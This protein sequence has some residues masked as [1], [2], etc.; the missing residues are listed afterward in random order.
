MTE[1]TTEV[2]RINISVYEWTIDFL[3]KFRAKGTKPLPLSTFIQFF[4]YCLKKSPAAFSYFLG[5]LSTPDLDAELAKMRK[6]G[7]DHL[8]IKKSKLAEEGED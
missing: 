6:F 1:S 3:D 2:E 7:E 5:K 4:S 8:K